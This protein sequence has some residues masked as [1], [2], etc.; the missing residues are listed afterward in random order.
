MVF[1]ILP[2]CQAV[3]MHFPVYSY[4]WPLMF[5]GSGASLRFPRY[6]IHFLIFCLE[7]GS[8]KERWWICLSQLMRKCRIYLVTLCF[9]K[10]TLSAKTDAQF[11]R[12]ELNFILG[13]MRTAAQETASQRTM[14]NCSKETVG[15]GQYVILVKGE[16]SAIKHLFYKRFPAT[17]EELKSSFSGLVLF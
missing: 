7:Q 8:W 12:C 6:E 15:E 2:K 9:E 14:R 13:K 10:W 17:C 4:P 5:T 3:I 16:F 11:E 1:L